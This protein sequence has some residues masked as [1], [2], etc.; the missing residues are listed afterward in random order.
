MQKEKQLAKEKKFC[1]ACVSSYLD[2]AKNQADAPFQ[3]FFSA[4]NC[5][6][7]ESHCPQRD[8]ETVPDPCNT[9]GNPIRARRPLPSV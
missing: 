6:R 1:E 2:K 7:P 8:S 5:Q 4:L 9:I 3:D